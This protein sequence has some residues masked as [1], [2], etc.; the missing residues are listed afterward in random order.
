ML[1]RL[2]SSSLPMIDAH[3]GLVHSPL[4]LVRVLYPSSKLLVPN[5]ASDGIRN[6]M[7]ILLFS[8][9]RS[10]FMTMAA[11]RILLPPKDKKS[12]SL[13]SC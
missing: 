12:S 7:A 3:R 2:V 5:G 4:S 9:L 6:G 1:E 11:R 13:S 8:R 10:L